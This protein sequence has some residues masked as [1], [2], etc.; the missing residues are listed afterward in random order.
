MLSMCELNF[1]EES[2]SIPKVFDLVSGLQHLVIYA[3]LPAA[4]CMKEQ[5]LSQYSVQ[6]L[7]R[8]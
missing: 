4:S 8:K 3:I 5:S 7:S 2:I 6:L 1:N